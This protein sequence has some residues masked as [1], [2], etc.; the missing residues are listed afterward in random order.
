MSTAD[1]VARVLR[2]GADGSGGTSV[3][4]RAPDRPL[5]LDEMLSAVEQHART[6]RTQH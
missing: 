6:L 4:V 2:Q 1:D 5:M 3:I